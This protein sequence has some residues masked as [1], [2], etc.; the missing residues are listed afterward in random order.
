MRAVTFGLSPVPLGDGPAGELW[1]P[2][3][4]EGAGPLEVDGGPDLLDPGAV[5]ALDDLLLDLLGLLH[6]PHGG[7]AG[8]LAGIVRLL[9]L[10][11]HGLLAGLSWK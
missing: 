2:G 7:L 1:V 6:L 11:R 3:G 8:G 5:G 4:S 9:G 10:L